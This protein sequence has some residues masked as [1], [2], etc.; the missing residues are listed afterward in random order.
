MI[1]ELTGIIV[2]TKD[3]REYDA[4]L[5]LLCVD[6]RLMTVSAR[7]IRKLKSKN[8][9]ACQL[10][11]HVRMQVDAQ[12]QKTIGSLRSAEI[13]NSYRHL[14]EELLKQSIAQ[15]F[16]ECIY[17]SQFEEN[18]FA[19]LKQSLDILTDT[20]HPLRILCLFQAI[21]NRMHG[22]E[23]FVDGCVRCKASSTIQGI[24]FESGGFVCVHCVKQSERRTRNDLR[25]FR[26]LCKASLEH[27]ELLARYPQFSVQNFEDLY[28]FFEEYGGIAIK[29]IHFLRQLFKLEQLS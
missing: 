8:A 13:V 4:L 25:I 3:Y 29:S 19:L 17:K 16:C 26:L 1:Q 10:F 9:A 2:D 21:M 7:G 22:I 5:K 20:S 12:P 27:Y 15:Y 11:T 23:P 14:R 28:Q 18:V 6:G 24:S